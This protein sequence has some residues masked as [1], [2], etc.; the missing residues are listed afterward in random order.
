MADIGAVSSCYI[1]ERVSESERA[2]TDMVV[3]VLLH[4]PCVTDLPAA[5]YIRARELPAVMHIRVMY[6]RVMCISE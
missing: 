6:I 1:R 2:V 3:A 4:P 5:I